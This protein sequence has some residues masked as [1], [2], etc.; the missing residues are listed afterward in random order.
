MREF[1]FRLQ[2]ILDVRR[3]TEDKRR[4][5]LGEITS[6][7]AYLKREIHARSELRRVS[8]TVPEPGA[9]LEDVSYRSAQAAFAAR[10]AVEEGRLREELVKAEE[11]REAAVGRYRE[12]RRDADVLE[13]LR[14]RRAAAYRKDQTRDEQ[15]RID[16]IAMSRRK[17]HGNAVQ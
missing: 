7:C 12:A 4:M 11:E 15:K 13:R 10:L 1:H 2:S 16:E 8:L 17:Q 5:E 6:R 9:R 3:Y 14:N